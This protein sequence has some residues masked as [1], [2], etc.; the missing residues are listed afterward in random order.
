MKS[1]I[2]LCLINLFLSFSLTAQFQKIPNENGAYYDLGIA[3]SS[4][5][6]VILLNLSHKSIALDSV[7][8]AVFSNLQT[9][10][11]SHDNLI[12]LPKGIEKLEKLKTLDIGANSFKTLPEIISKIPNLEELYLNNEKYL[13]LNQAF[14]I[15]NKITHLKRLHL[16]S[17]PSST[18]PKDIGLNKSIEYLSL[19]Y[20]GMSKIPSGISKIV[21]L[22]N[23]DLEGNSISSI[24]KEFLKNKEIEYINLSIS[25]EFNFKKAFLLLSK[26]PNLNALT[27][28]NSHLDSIPA[29]ISLLKNITSLSLRNDHLSTF[30]KGILKLK[31]LKNLDLSGNDFAALPPSFIVLESLETLDLSQDNYLDFNQ[32]AELVKKLP[33]LKLIQVGQYDYTFDNRTYSD[34]KQNINFMEVLPQEHQNNIIHLFKGINNRAFP[35]HNAPINN[36][37]PEGFGVKIGW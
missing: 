20:S 25:P 27:I 37:N 18:F 14:A 29:E 22:K 23:L 11:L 4:P 17:L 21:H 34:F 1:I 13:D 9:L 8:I 5:K 6:S 16:D 26:E 7:D 32:T 31:N 15:I 30:P 36:F 24:D 35:P 2:F 19:R 28:S 3:K 33:R 12:E 10:I